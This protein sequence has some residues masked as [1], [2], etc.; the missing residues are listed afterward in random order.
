MHLFKIISPHTHRQS[1][2][3]YPS[4]P[5][6]LHTTR[7]RLVGRNRTQK[8][9]KRQTFKADRMLIDNNLV[10]N[11]SDTSL[12][13]AQLK[14]LNKGL[15]FVPNNTK[16][17]FSNIDKE[18]ERFERRLQI[19]FFF[20]QKTL[21]ETEEIP[22]IN[23]TIQH[24]P[25]QKNSDWWP[26][27]LNAHITEFCY[28]LKRKMYSLR[29]K[30][31]RHNL[32]QRELTALKTL[33]NNADII[34][35]KCDKGG[36]IAIMNKRDYENKI[37]QMVT[38]TNTYTKTN[39][40]DTVDTKTQAD[41]IIQKLQEDGYINGKQTNYLTNF[42]PKC[43]V[44]YGIPKIHKPNWPLR[45]IVS[46][47]NGPSCRLNELIDKYLYVAEK[48]I[49]NLLQDTT[50]YLQ[51]IKRNRNCT[52]DTFLV[53]MDI[54]SLYTNIPHEEGA[55]WVSEYYETTL[56]NWDDYAYTIKPI[57]RNT[58]KTLLL[59]IL[60]HT[61]FEFNNTYYKQNYGTTMG[62]IFSV[63][64]ANIYMH[65]FFEKKLKNYAGTKPNFIARLV[66]DC[67]FTWYH[68]ENELKQLLAYLN[69]CHTSIKFEYQYSHEKVSFLDTITYIENNTIKTTLYTKPTDRKQYL[70]YTSSHPFHIKK[71]IPYSQAIR[72]RR[73]IEDDNLFTTQI[74]DLKIKFLQRGYPKQLI[75]NQLN[76][77]FNLDRNSTLVYKSDAQKKAENN[78]FLN[79]NSFLPL[80]I[81]YS[82]SLQAA[83]FRSIFMQKW[84]DFTH[85]DADIERIFASEL[86][87]IV[88]KKGKTLANIL[89]SS[90]FNNK[91]TETDRTNINILA[92]LLDSNNTNDNTSSVKK[93][94]ENRCKCCKHITCT[95]VFYNTQKT[96]EYQINDNFNCNSKNVIYIIICK[97]CHKMYVGQTSR[98]LKE[99]LTNHRS[100]IKLHKNTPIAKHFTLP[101][102][103]LHHLSIIPI[104]NV[105]SRTINEILKIEKDYMTTLNTIHPVG[106]N[107]YPTI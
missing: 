97:H 24:P 92:S 62:A 85:S 19:H 80:I 90:K 101:Q 98:K 71:A 59:F 34:I 4:A 27:K 56:P 67:F 26:R 94:N 23:D 40:D 69:S 42:E 5:T 9:K 75:E 44:F 57:D 8:R 20:R 15:G 72:Y 78:K 100:D 41:S 105:E 73:I 89:I 21:G 35:K 91:L 81:T 64:F 36:G 29:N 70:H 46:Q 10:T 11:L 17:M 33:K 3:V 65:M 7:R 96:C 61:T 55:D 43:P 102:H 47:I 88:Y 107:F 48:S 25:L 31:V 74:H 52:A 6:N 22:P 77:V 79:G 60:Q 95:S 51:T 49:P 37:T 84:T 83:H 1:Y 58:L 45:P 99:R 104:L 87:Q 76:R 63:K 106:I 66:D 68:T 93:C 14:V 82:D 32:S 28:Q 13:L 18:I 2:N 86:P 54:V 53:T 38:D 103:K 50:A 30:R 16:P 39:I 12:T